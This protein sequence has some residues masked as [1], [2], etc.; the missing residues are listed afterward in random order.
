MFDLE[1]IR[2]QNELAHRQAVERAN[3]EDGLTPELASG[4]VYPLAILSRLLITGPPSLSHLFDLLENSDVVY[5]FHQLVREYLPEHEAFIM[6]QDTEGRIREFA[7]YFEQQYFPLSDNLLMEEYS[8]GD[9]L[10]QIPVDL[11]GFNY[12]DYHQFTDFRDGYTLMLALVES[13]YVDD[14]EGGRI[15]ILERVGELVG[16]RLM[17]LLPPEGWSTEDLHRML[18]GS[19]FEGAAAFA[20][21]VHCETGLWQLDATYDEYEGEPWE[22]HIVDSLTSQRA[23]VIEYQDK[24]QRMSEWLEEDLD[25][26]FEELLSHMLDR[27]EIIIPKEQ[28][29]LPLDE[30]CQVVSKEVLANANH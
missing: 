8:L 21:W 4:H 6:S 25:H 2:A 11:M 19:D 3:E 17:G 22:R 15:P 30:S 1:V 16:K 24:I 7:H 5:D 20:D 18:D 29:P 23:E 14:G 26:R 13:P 28:L 9:F 12:E 27:K 10:F